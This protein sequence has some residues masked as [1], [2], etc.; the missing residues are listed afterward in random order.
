MSSAPV[1]LR[2]GLNDQSWHVQINEIVRNE[3]NWKRDAF[4]EV[5]HCHENPV[6]SLD[7]SH[8]LTSLLYM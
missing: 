5:E 2:A 7:Y 3:E 6:A 8:A 4:S 1:V